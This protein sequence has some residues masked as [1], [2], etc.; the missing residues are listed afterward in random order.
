MLTEY[1]YN[2]DHS[3]PVPALIRRE[4]KYPFT[5]MAVGDSFH[6]DEDEFERASRAAYAYGRLHDMK[7][8]CRGSMNRIWRI[9]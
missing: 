8:A 9:A 2:V 4:T 6:V 7:F 1:R 5:Q 3:I